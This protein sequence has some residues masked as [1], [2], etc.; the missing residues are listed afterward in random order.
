MS[1]WSRVIHSIDRLLGEPEPDYNG[2]DPEFVE[3]AIR[4]IQN[5]IDAEGGEREVRRLKVNDLSPERR[6]E[7]REQLARLV[8]ERARR[9]KRVLD[10][11]STSE[12]DVA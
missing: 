5:Q 11:D 12:R 9:G 10:D 8:Q 2:M 7:L 4:L 3:E 1:F 6:G